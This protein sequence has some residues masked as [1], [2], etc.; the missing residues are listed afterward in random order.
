MDLRQLAALAAV[1]DHRSFSAAARAL[2]TV[3]SNVSSHIAN[4][5]RELG[6]ALVDRATGD[7]TEQG[8]L[9]LDRARRVQAELDAVAADL[10]AHAGTVTGRVRLGMIGT[11]GAWLL[12]LL[13][14]DLA[15]S[16]PGIH[17]VVVD[18][19]T[20]SLIPQVVAG[21]L[22][23]AVVNL[24]VTAPDLRAEPLFEEERVVLAP[25]GHPL[26]RRRGARV[27]LAELARHPLLLEPPGTAFRDDLDSAAARVG[28]ELTALA[29]I[30]GMRALAA[31]A[32]EGFGA[33]VLP[34]TAAPIP[35]PTGW[36]RLEVTGLGPRT[37]GL[38]TSRR[39]R[40][41]APAR[42]ATAELRT[43]LAAE[44]P[45]RPGLRLL[46]PG[47]GDDGDAASTGADPPL[48]AG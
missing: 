40:P 20:T 34:A 18:A 32:Q 48:P 35:P 27:P 21:T 7:L 47:E 29:E 3:Q 42:A 11:V 23:V 5:E 12:P 24:P 22:D 1:A 37:V 25:P 8:R 15:R 14:P 4:L 16:H 36:R 45:T 38:A 17:L 19:T 39:S 44:V 2:H 30:D 46:A 26:A 31:L 33:A 41:T 10:A 43:L 13:I 28:V 9:V 6:V